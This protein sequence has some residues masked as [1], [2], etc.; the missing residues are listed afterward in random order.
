MNGF[1]P[2][3]SGLGGDRSTTEPQP[4]PI[5]RNLLRTNVVRVGA[6]QAKGCKFFGNFT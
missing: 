3:I 5:G 6:K 4:L 1:E 2:R